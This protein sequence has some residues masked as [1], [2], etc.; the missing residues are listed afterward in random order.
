MRADRTL[1]YYQDNAAELAARYE[2][3]DVTGLH[4]QLLGA[5]EKGSRLL[6]IGGGS[7]REAAFLLA[8]GHDV[9][10]SDGARAMLDQA[11]AI[12]PELCGRTLLYRCP[13]TIPRPA[14]SFAGVYALA[15]LM[16]LC[17]QD[18]EATL[19]QVA[20]VLEDGGRLFFSVPFRRDDVDAHDRDS[21]GRLFTSLSPDQWCA[22]GRKAGLE[23]VSSQQNEDG[24]GR[25]GIEW[26]SMLM[27]RSGAK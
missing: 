3:A 19:V 7:G 25:D 14:G 2:S 17:P 4:I 24:L 11:E 13:E 18:I 15:S 16:H 5:F 27:S 6:E 22:L 12:H 10:L 9:L 20:M 1:R 26:V 23:L 21:N 8:N